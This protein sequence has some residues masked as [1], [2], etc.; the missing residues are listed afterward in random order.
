MKVKL[1]QALKT[2]Y[3]DLGLSA[4]T[5]EGVA[6]QLANSVKEE[7]E[8]ENA[9][10]GVSP[11]LKAIQSEADRRANKSLSELNRLKDEVKT[12]NEKLTGQGAGGTP[13]EPKP[14]GDEVP[15]WAKSLTEKLEK[16]EVGYSAY[17]AERKSD[18]LLQQLNSILAEKKIPSSFSNVAL[19]GRTFKDEAEVE[20]LAETIATQFEAFKQDS[21]NTGFSYTAPPQSGTPPKKDSDEIANLINQ[22]TKEIVEQ[23]KN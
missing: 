13:N 16:L 1:L 20:A 4:E 17:N 22:G 10:A 7:T 12:L 9:V 2:K 5:L 23:A 6:N 14:N 19:S 8:I 21:A 18:T 11:M 3:S 15:S